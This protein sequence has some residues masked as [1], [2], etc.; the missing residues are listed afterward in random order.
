LASKNT[1]KKNLNNVK[2][3]YDNLVAERS[4]LQSSIGQAIK[5][6]KELNKN[7]YKKYSRFIQ[8]GTWHSEDYI[9]DERYYLDA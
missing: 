2:S 4:S 7:F 1:H 5:S 9:E 8:E 6:K 3:Q